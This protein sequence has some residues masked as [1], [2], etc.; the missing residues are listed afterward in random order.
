MKVRTQQLQLA[1]TGLTLPA[2]NNTADIMNSNRSD[3]AQLKQSMSSDRISRMGSALCSSE[4]CL[5]PQQL[6]SMIIPQASFQLQ[7]YKSADTTF[8]IH[9]SVV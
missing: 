3:F 6:E 7:Y 4:R 9:E 5:N 8:H 1:K 2:T